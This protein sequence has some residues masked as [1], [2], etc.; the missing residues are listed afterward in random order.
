MTESNRLKNFLVNGFQGL[1]A[2]QEPEMGDAMEDAPGEEA[3]AEQTAETIE[4]RAAEEP[5][6]EDLPDEAPRGFP[7]REAPSRREDRDAETLKG[8]EKEL[9]TI[10]YMLEDLADRP[11]PEPPD[12]SAYVTTREQAKTMNATVAKLDSSSSNKTLVHAMEQIALMR[13]DFF[14]LCRGMERRIGELDAG[15]VLAS[16]KAYEVDMENILADA[17]VYIGSFDYER[18][19][20]LHQ[21]IVG[22]VPT[23]E[24]EKDGT[25]AERQ[26]D[27]YKL[28]DKVLLKE[29]VAVFKYAPSEP[30]EAAE[31]TVPGTGGASETSSETTCGTG[32][33]PS[34]D[35]DG[36]EEKE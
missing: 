1:E 17:G 8:I 31:E 35:G 21:R 19:N 11:A 4:D 33:E 15:T 25:I 2:N 36:M 26:S 27:G 18:L 6:Q 5:V 13:E 32:P 23:G 10:R 30:P 34:E 28:G 9:I 16:F 12:M 14:R 22:V 7:G 29:K 3:G 24:K 20:T